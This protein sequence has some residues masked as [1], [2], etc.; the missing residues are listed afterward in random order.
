MRAG[1]LNQRVTI[2]QLAGSPPQDAGGAPTQDWADLV[3]VFASV[4]PLRGREFIAAQGVNSEVTGQI[5][6]RYYPGVTSAMRAK[7]GTRIYEIIAVV[8]VDERNAELI[9][10]VKEGPTSG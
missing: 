3:T 5:R 2:Q 10:Y 6:M 7:M 1:R 8:N 9:L 4:E